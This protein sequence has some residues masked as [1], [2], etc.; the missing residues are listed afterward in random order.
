MNIMVNPFNCP[1]PNQGFTSM[2]NP[3][4]DM[5]GQLAGN[6]GMMNYYQTLNN[7]E[8]VPEYTKN[9]GFDHFC[10]APPEIIAA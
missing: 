6:H 7:P 9:L 2:M 10:R 1:F 8:K 3:Y 4:V 5:Q